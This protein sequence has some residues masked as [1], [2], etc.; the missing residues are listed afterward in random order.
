[1]FDTDVK[2]EQKVLPP[3]WTV[4]NFYQKAVQIKTQAEKRRMVL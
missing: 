1:M 2:I 4:I 3:S